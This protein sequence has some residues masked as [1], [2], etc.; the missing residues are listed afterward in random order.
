MIEFLQSDN[1]WV[2]FIIFFGKIIEVTLSTLRMVL[3]NKGEKLKGSL[4]AFVEVILWVFITGTVLVGF[5]EAPLKAL[6]FAVAYALGNYLGC[7]L[8]EKLALGLSTVE[9]ITTEEEAEN[10]VNIIRNNNLAVTVVDGQ[11]K[12]GKRKILKIHLKRSRIN[13]TCRL[14]NKNTTNCM[15]SVSSVKVLRGGYIKK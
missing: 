8:E 13:A 6:V 9:V 5:A 12:E 10:L 7:W 1:I 15:I 11:G 2:Y 4:L 14:I 3:I